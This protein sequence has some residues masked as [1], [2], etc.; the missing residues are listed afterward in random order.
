MVGQRV[1][2]NSF[3]PN[4]FCILKFQQ[5][6][7]NSSPFGIPIEGQTKEKI[8]LAESVIPRKICFIWHILF[9]MRIWR[10]RELSFSN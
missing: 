2:T 6:S 4:I 5:L 8:V 3:D 10:N 9:W 7:R 1:F